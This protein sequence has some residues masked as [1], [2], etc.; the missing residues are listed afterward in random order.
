MKFICSTFLVLF[1]ATTAF[2][3]A[4]LWELK[5]SGS[6]LGGPIDVEQFNPNNVYYGSNNI[7]YKSTDRGETFMQMGINVPQAS[8]I[9]CVLVAGL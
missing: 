6:S 5:Q 1:I 2:S 9:K 4:Y 8:E 3:Q 7:I